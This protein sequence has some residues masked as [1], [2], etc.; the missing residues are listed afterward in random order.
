MRQDFFATRSFESL[1]HR[2][3]CFE[4][5][6]NE[7]AN[8]RRHGS[9]GKIVAEAFEA[10]QRALQTLAAKPFE[11]LLSLQ[12]KIDREGLVSYEGNRYSVPNGTGVR[13]VAVQVLPMELLIVVESEVI[14]RHAIATGKGHTIVDPSHRKLRC[15]ARGEMSK[16]EHSTPV[17]QR[18]LLFYQA[19]G[20]RLAR[21]SQKVRS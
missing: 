1:E 12:R 9:T 5:W 3:E 13:L 11:A 19:V 16:P 2:N 15:C 6:L 7:V 8:Q 14:A 17:A 4:N 18:S 20:T 21:Q 10:E